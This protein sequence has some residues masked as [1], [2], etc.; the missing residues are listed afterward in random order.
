MSEKK[1]SRY[2]PLI[3][4]LSIAV[5]ITIGSF[6]S[7]HFAGNRLNI[8]T[9]S[10]SKINDLLQIINDKYVD[11][12]NLSDLV[13]RSMPRILAELDPHSTYVSASEIDDE[14]QSIKGSFSGIG[15]MFTLFNDTARVI[16]VIEGGPSEQVGIMAGD[17][18]VKVDGK[19]FV[20]DSITDTYAMK[21]LKGP[22]DSKIKLG[23]LRHGEKKIRYFTVVR[24]DVAVNSIDIAYMIS[25]KTGF[26]RVNS[27]SDNTY[28]EMLVALAKLSNQGMNKLILDLR[29][30][31]GGLMAPAIQ[32]A[33][34]FLPSNRM[35]TYIEGRHSKRQEYKSDGRGAYQSMPL[36]I[37]ID[38]STASA[39]EV[40]TAA[41]QDNDRAIVV[42]RRSFGKGLVQEPIQFRDGSMIRLTIARY[43]SPSGRCV[44]KPYVFGDTDYQNELLH[45]AENG[46]FMHKDSIHLKGKEY[47]TR[48][49]RIVYGEAGVM[50]DYFVPNDT[51]DV[52]SYY[53]EAINNR[54]LPQFA[55]E[56]V[57]SHREEF[58]NVE[59]DQMVRDLKNASLPNKFANYAEKRGLKRRN[60]MIKKSYQLLQDALITMVF[61]YNND[62]ESEYRY[63]N[64]S[65]KTVKKALK[66]F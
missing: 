41:M 7:S 35:I 17:K 10:S 51:S 3:I 16:K 5:G 38:E 60:L 59:F 44:Q 25:P 13:E 48:K 52:T 65:D 26:I 21:H 1:P 49:G 39:S 12:V 63:A 33:N 47:K 56:Y 42:G 40:F 29:G 37:L 50:P 19:S 8:I 61:S 15:I 66:S 20:G 2:T 62:T 53:M 64:M 55:F 28:A 34:E 23:V 14:M 58:K 43:Y 11:K 27:F 30:N 46:E 32:I 45:R 31:R 57:D 36:V 22:K 4:T 54:L 18:I 9:N 6:Y 24:N